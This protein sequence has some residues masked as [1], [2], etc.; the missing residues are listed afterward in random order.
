MKVSK[1]WYTN[2]LVGYEAKKETCAIKF[3]INRGTT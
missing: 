1:T 2:S 3:K